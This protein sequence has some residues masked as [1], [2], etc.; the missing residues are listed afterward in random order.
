VAIDKIKNSQD[1]PEILEESMQQ[2]MHY[3]MQYNQL[4]K[5][6]S[7]EILKQFDVI[8]EDIHKGDKT[9]IIAQ[10]SILNLRV[11]SFL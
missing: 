4:T 2:V 1:N 9:K 5:L 10:G 7:A 6:L 11:N 3:R 8:T